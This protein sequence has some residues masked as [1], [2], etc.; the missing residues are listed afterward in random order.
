MR[1]VTALWVSVS[2]LFFASLVFRAL[3]AQRNFYRIL[4]TS[5]SW[6][7]DIVPGSINVILVVGVLLELANSPGAVFVNVGFFLLVTGWI[8]VEVRHGWPDTGVRTFGV[9]LHILLFLVLA[10]DILLYMGKKRFS[11]AERPA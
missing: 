6:K 2:N 11:Q 5:M 8:A 1:I 3:L 9:P 10:T 7:Y 4:E